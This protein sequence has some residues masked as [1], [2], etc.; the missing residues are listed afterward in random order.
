MERKEAAVELE[1]LREQIRYHSKKYYTEDDPEISD[2][3]Y[4][5][6]YRQLEDLEAEFPELVSPAS[7]T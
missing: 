7:P 4:D 3:E 6:L 2:R 5:M 1:K